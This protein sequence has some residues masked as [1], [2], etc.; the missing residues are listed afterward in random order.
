MSPAL[1]SADPTPEKLQVRLVH[2]GGLIT[3]VGATL[4]VGSVIVTVLLT[5]RLETPHSSFTV[6]VTV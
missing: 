1:L 4:S 6:S 2:A 5:G 3:G